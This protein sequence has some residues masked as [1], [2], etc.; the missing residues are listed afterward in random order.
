M[1]IALL[2]ARLFFGLG[3]AAHGAQKLLGWFGGGGLNK[4]GEFFVQLGW[5]QGRF[6]ATAASLGEVGGGLLLALGFLGPVGPAIMVLVLTTAALTVHVHNGF[7]VGKNG[8]ELPLLYVAGALVFMF[9]GPGVWSL[10][11]VVGLEWLSNDHYAWIALATALV[12]ALA[13]VALRRP[14]RP[15]GV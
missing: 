4:T 14:P 8:V 9:T 6:F 11:H 10:D 13:N 3:L 12:I 1:D 15:A 7:F 2:I 5:N